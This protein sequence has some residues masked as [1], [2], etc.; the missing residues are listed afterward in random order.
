M[1]KSILGIL[2]ATLAWPAFAQQPRSD[3]AALSPPANHESGVVG[4]VLVARDAG[5]SQVGSIA[6]W[7]G[8]QIFVSGLPVKMPRSGDILDFPVCRSV[9]DGRKI[10]RFE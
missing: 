2:L 4:G 7:R 5:Y 6:R 10:L 8:A 3:S 9:Q 1:R